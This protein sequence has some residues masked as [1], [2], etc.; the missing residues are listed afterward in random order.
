M[1]WNAMIGWMWLGGGLVNFFSAN[2]WIAWA[3]HRRPS[4]LER[5]GMSSEDAHFGTILILFAW[6]VVALYLLAIAAGRAAA[7]RQGGQS[8]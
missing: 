4:P 3:E 8:E 6:P 7:A 5:L 2:A 1:D